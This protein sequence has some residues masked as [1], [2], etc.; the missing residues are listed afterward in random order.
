MVEPL[1]EREKFLAEKYSFL[2]GKL[3]RLLHFNK[4]EKDDNY[5]AA[6]SGLIEGVRS[7]DKAAEAKIFIDEDDKESYY[8][9]YVLRV[10]HNRVCDSA[11]D[12]RKLRNGGNYTH[13]SMSAPLLSASDEE[14][15]TVED[16]VEDESSLGGY[17]AVDDRMYIEWLLQGCTA[18]QRAICLYIAYGYPRKKIAEI[19]NITPRRITRE[20]EKIRTNS[21]IQKTRPAK[22]SCNQNYISEDKGRCRIAFYVGGKR[23]RVDGL[24]PER[25]VEVRDELLHLRE[26]DPDL[27]IKRAKELQ[28]EIRSR[29]NYKNPRHIRKY[30]NFYTV[31][32]Q[33][34]GVL[35]SVGMIPTLEEAIKVRDNLLAAR[36][37]GFRAFYDMLGSYRAEYGGGK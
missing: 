13:I 24:P 21:D 11:N 17:K 23:I 31:R 15:G 19:L 32:L 30:L 25:A 22:S 3:F 12:K 1:S 28:E 33:V 2:I 10:I 35:E 9:N 14:G 27:A 20:L 26:Q 5:C 36:S 18:L 6:A 4:Q 16:R 29:K 37:R 7:V 34:D 8:E